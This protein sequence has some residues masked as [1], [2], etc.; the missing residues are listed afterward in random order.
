MEPWG[1]TRT[2]AGVG[3]KSTIEPWNSSPACAADSQA[4]TCR[5]EG[6]PPEASGRTHPRSSRSH[7]APAG[8]YR[9]ALRRER[10]S[11]RTATVQAP[12]PS[13]P[14]DTCRAGNEW[15]EA[16]R[17]G[18]G[19]T[20]FH[21]SYSICGCPLRETGR[22]TQ[23][24]HPHTCPPLRHHT[25]RPRCSPPR[26]VPD[27]LTHG[28]KQVAESSPALT[29]PSPPLASPLLPKHFLSLFRKLGGPTHYRNAWP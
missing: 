25:Q 10:V 27:K 1:T 22:A 19:S 21:R 16:W 23:R 8:H 18:Q 15:D 5:R 11:A 6:T 12:A 7:P 17:C 3:R 4:P 2:E 26:I 24:P 9:Y 29:V 13:E 20:E 28:A 14:C